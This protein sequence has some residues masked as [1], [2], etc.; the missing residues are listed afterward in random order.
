MIRASSKVP[1]IYQ[2]GEASRIGCFG[3]GFM[4]LLLCSFSDS[5]AR[6][7]SHQPLYT[8]KDVTKKRKSK[9]ESEKC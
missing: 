6:W 3:V 4:V 1:G 7:F 9:F 8:L 5:A 2:V